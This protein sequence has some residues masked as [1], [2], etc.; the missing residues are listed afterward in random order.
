MG[1]K[2]TSGKSRHLRSLSQGW[3]IAD[4]LFVTSVLSPSGRRLAGYRRLFPQSDVALRACRL[5]L[6]GSS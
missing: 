5:A 6:G 4:A 1:R 2:L 3:R